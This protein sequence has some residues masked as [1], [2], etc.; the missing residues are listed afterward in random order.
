MTQISPFTV[1]RTIIALAG[2]SNFAGNTKIN[3]AT[4]GYGFPTKDPVAP[5]G[6]AGSWIPPYV[7]LMG[8]AGHMVKV[9]NTAHGASSIKDHWLGRIKAWAAGTIYYGQLTLSDGG[10]W[11]A[12]SSVAKYGTYVASIT[13]PTGTSNT[14]LDTIDWNYLGVPAAYETNGYICRPGDAHFDPLGFVA[15]MFTGRVLP[16]ASLGVL[17]DRGM[18][19]RRMIL[20]E[21]GQQE[22]LTVHATTEDEFFQCLVI[23]VEYAKTKGTMTG[24]GLSCYPGNGTNDLIYTNRLIPGRARAL[25]YF[26][27]DPMV[28][29]S[30]NWRTYPA[31]GILPIEAS[32]GDSYTYPAL[33]VDTLH[34]N[35]AAKYPAAQA[36]FEAQVAAGLV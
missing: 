35:D 33:R 14:V 24:I 19:D 34:F 15:E 7:E 23:L 26:A 18:W 10:L 31:L 9:V 29:A 6:Y 16:T 3:C 27:N 30:A 17:N 28:F 2:Q 32:A 1:K 36:I 8:A 13:A 5:E 25:A 11:I 20:T 22:C 4:G 12:N 21:F